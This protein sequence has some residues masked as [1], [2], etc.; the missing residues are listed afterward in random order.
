MT[1][2]ADRPGPGAARPYRFPP[3]V[4]RAVAGG[5]VVAAHLPG[6]NLAVALLLLDVGAGQEPVGKEGLVRRCWPR[7]WRRGPRSGTPPRTRS[8]SRG[9]APRCRP[10]WTGT[11]SRPAWWSRW[12]G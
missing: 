6:Q 5:Q 8:P 12:T 10:G 4:R 7:R 1:L 2:I 3:V 9:S 11:R